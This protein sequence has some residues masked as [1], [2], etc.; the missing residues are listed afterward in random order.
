MSLRR[1]AFPVLVVTGVVLWLLAAVVMIELPAGAR[2]LVGAV[3]G[4]VAAA[5]VRGLPGRAAVVVVGAGAVAVAALGLGAGAMYLMIGGG[6][7]DPRLAILLGFAS[8]VAA[9]A[10]AQALVPG[11]TPLHVAGGHLLVTF[12]ISVAWAIASGK[13]ELLVLAPLSSAL[14]LPGVVAAALVQRVR[15]RRATALPAARLV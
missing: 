8:L 10:A 6:V 15:R 11:C 13:P 4:I 1:A 7:D 12:T 3:G 14:W 5:L 9:G 2:A